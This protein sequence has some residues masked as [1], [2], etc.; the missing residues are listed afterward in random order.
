[1]LQN[2]AFIRKSNDF[3]EVFVLN[4]AKSDNLKAFIAN[5]SYLCTINQKH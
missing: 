3:S 4:F 2:Y 1:M 5:F